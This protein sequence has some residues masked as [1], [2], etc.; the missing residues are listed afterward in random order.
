MTVGYARTCA[1]VGLAAAPV[2]VEAVVTPGL[3]R[4]TIVGLPDAAVTEARERIRAAFEASGMG[5]P[6]AKVT[7]SLAPADL[8]KSGSR[9]DVPI[10]IAVCRAC[11]FLPPGEEVFM[12]E[13]GLDGSVRPVRGVFTVLAGMLEREPR[14]C[15]YVP[16]DNAREAR[17]CDGVTVS[18]IDSLRTLVEHLA[19]AV[20]CGGG[21][22]G[23]QRPLDVNESED[24]GAHLDLAHVRGQAGVI[25]A[26]RI[27]AAG[28]HD[29][30][31]LGSAGVGK[32]MAAMRM[33]TILP[34]LTVRQSLEV[35]K[36]QSVAGVE[37]RGLP[38]RPPFVKVGATI[39]RAGLLGGGAGVPTI[40]ALTRAHHG[41]LFIDEF[42]EVSPEILSML[43]EPLEEREVVLTRHAGVFRFPADAHVVAASNPC[44][45]GR[46]LEGVRTCTCSY[47]SV[48]SYMRVVA[49]PLADRIDLTCAVRTPH[50][51]DLD[52]TPVSSA[53]V[54]AAVIEARRRQEERYADLPWKV[55]ARAPLS[56]LEEHTDVPRVVTTRFAAALRNGQLSMR[57]VVKVLRIAWTLADLD[58]AARPTPD[59][60]EYARMVRLESDVLEVAA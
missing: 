10:A 9:F 46:R 21:E 33:P 35:A 30:L 51:F 29:L 11:G 55:N 54:K 53:D 12:G 34:D 6:R 58:G 31:L 19:S 15:A 47:S 40:G 1:L 57:G 3:P 45:C 32:T 41:V 25:E 49:G 7:V 8:R 52:I 43:R 24:D 18:G 22:A 26:M 16:A 48:K 42:A 60:L 39:T 44:P 37:F 2:R 59:H 17:A 38:V 5:W 36:I 4:F 23:E 14:F 28:K 13:L 20:P 27:A 50:S 56:W